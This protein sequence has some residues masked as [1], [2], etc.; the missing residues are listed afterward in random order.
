[1]PLFDRGH[2]LPTSTGWANELRRDQVEAAVK[3]PDI[4]DWF[5]P[6]V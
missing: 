3:N 5:V 2:Q 6:E 4:E 1:V